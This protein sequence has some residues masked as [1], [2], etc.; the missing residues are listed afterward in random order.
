MIL[1]EM[2]LITLNNFLVNFS[3]KENI[4]ALDHLTTNPKNVPHRFSILKVSLNTV[5]VDR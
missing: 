1:K 5:P 3:S 4:V 2:I